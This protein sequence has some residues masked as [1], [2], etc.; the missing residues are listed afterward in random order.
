[1]REIIIDTDENYQFSSGRLYPI[2]LYE[3]LGDGKVE[4]LHEGYIDSCLDYLCNLRDVSY[5]WTDNDEERITKKLKFY[6]REKGIRTD[7]N[8][9][10]YW[11]IKESGFRKRLISYWIE[12]KP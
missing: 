11:Y 7:I 10:A 3:Y 2:V 6:L 8:W 12:M 4:K 5:I 9:N 1:M